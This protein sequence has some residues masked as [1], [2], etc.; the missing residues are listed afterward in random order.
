MRKN[1]T[2]KGK[3]TVSIIAKLEQFVIPAKARDTV[4]EE[5][6]GGLK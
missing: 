3:V 6:L 1:I 5:A 2:N 4:T